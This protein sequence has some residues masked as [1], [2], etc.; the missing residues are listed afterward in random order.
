MRGEFLDKG[1]VAINPVFVDLAVVDCSAD[2][3]TGFGV[4]DTIAEA[5]RTGEL[6]EV[7]EHQ[8]K[9][10]LCLPQTDGADSGR[11]E[12][13]ARVVVQR[14]E[15]ASGRG[16]APLG[17]GLPNV[18]DLEQFLADERVHEGGFAHAAGADQ[19]ES[20]GGGKPAPELIE[21]ARVDRARGEHGDVASDGAHDRLRVVIEGGVGLRQDHQ[22]L[23]TGVVGENEKPLKSP[24]WERPV[25]AVDDRHALH[26][27]RQNLF[28][29]TFRRVTPAHL[30]G[31]V[32]DM[33]D[34]IA[35]SV[36]FTDHHPVTS[37]GRDLVLGSL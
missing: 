32:E 19:S 30:G 13:Q 36:L 14:N 7:A 24:R 33:G 26:V 34:D 20:L 11:V 23:G 27:R 29:I 22:R 28:E 21:P 18:T 2:S 15:F 10:V 37:D 35:E 5:T 16:V 3:A 8:I 12:D 6:L 4:V 31:S 9:S 25:Q 1:A 17:V